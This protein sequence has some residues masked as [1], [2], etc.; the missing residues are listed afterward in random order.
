[1]SNQNGDLKRDLL[2]DPLVRAEAVATLYK[3]IPANPVVS[4]LVTLLLTWQV[5][6]WPKH[7][8][9]FVTLALWVAVNSLYFCLYL[10]HKK[11]TRRSPLDPASSQGY[12]QLFFWA[13]LLD[14]IVFGL[15]C[16]M[17]YF[18]RP[19]MYAVATVGCAIYLFG[20]VFKNTVYAR[21][22]NIFP[23]V[24]FGPLALT[25]FYVGSPTL[26]T[27]AIIL[28]ISIFAML[29]FSRNNAHT[30]QLAIKQRFD[31]GRQN[32]ELALLTARLEKERERADAANA[33][34]S[35]FF[36]AASHDAR[37]P[38]QVISLL[39]QTFRN[40]GL[41]SEDDRKIVEKID[42]NLKTIRTLFDRVLDI[43]RID[44][45]HVTPRMQPLSLQAQF[46]KLDAQ[47]GELAASQGLWLRFVAT[48]E[49]VVHDPEL[50]DRIVSNLIH[51]A[52]KYTER[53]GVWVA[54][55]RA[56]GRLEIRDS[57]LGISAVD[58]QT[59][60]QEFAQLN[61]PSRN[62]EAGLGLGLSIV[63]RLADLTHSSVGVVSS[64]NKGS[65]FWLALQAT[66]AQVQAPGDQAVFQNAA[67]LRDLHIL[68]VDDEVQLLELLGN[69]LRDAGATV[70]LCSNVD[71]ARVILASPER[72]DVV[73]TDYRL[74]LSGTG[75]DVVQAGRSRATSGAIQRRLPAAILTGDSAVKDLEAIR[76]LENCALL[77]KP[78][79]FETLSRAL[80]DLVQASKQQFAP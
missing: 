17:V 30:L 37:Q 40:S 35:K 53:G 55:R 32:E 64:L 74:G 18:A 41:A 21:L 39:F 7:W 19:E 72:V 63:K 56:R 58:Q 38:L 11:T 34:K 80:L 23:F 67:S 12:L 71:Q 54:W 75:L 77:H 24:I 44:S 26:V 16:V 46:D 59:I 5:L 47:F 6:E 66:S 69:L 48:D 70:Y 51:N 27:L 25:Y 65:C 68:Y 8:A 36:T 10:H 31:L 42:V 15:I 57:G 20:D 49:W 73:L 76:A 4:V 52:I 28:V 3:L 2:A 22:T 78:V 61:N 60:F 29:E 62:N 1:M 9:S 13:A 43:S 79:E 45:G 50:F 14:A 33:A